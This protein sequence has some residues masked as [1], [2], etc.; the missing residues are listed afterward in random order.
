MQL[1]KIAVI[2]KPTDHVRR[3]QPGT[4]RVK[5]VRGGKLEASIGAGQ[6]SQEACVKKPARLDY[7]HASGAAIRVSVAQPEKRRRP[8]N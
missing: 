1:L 6:G 4:E 3:N 5:L 8:P 2:E 7:D